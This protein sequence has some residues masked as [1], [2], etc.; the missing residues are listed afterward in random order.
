MRPVVIARRGRAD[1]RDIGDV[2]ANDDPKRAVTFVAERR[3]RCRSRSG[4]PFQGRP[5]PEIAADVRILVFPSY[6]ILH[7]V[8]DEAVLID[9]VIHSARDR[10][11]L[12][13]YE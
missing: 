12:L 11:G 7:R 10:S 1:L 2:I 9:R 3:V 13:P 8:S 5:A 4:T 6:L